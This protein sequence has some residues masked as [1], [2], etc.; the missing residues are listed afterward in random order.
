LLCHCDQAIVAVGT[1]LLSL[2]S[3]NYSNQLASDVASGKK[4]FGQDFRKLKLP[5]GVILDF[6]SAVFWGFDDDVDQTL[7]ITPAI[8]CAG[9][10][11]L[12]DTF[13]P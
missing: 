9:F 2:P 12:P 6:I 5:A 7:S 8:V 11:S 3:F 1:A 4:R 13:R 10:S